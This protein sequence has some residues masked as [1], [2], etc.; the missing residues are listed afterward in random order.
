LG[1]LQIA[2]WGKVT[3]KSSGMPLKKLKMLSKPAK[4]RAGYAELDL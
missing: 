2:W 3:L 4:N 1:F